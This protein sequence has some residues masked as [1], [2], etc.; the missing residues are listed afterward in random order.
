MTKV[1]VLW[2]TRITWV[3]YMIS[4]WW[5][6]SV[7]INENRTYRF[8]E[9]ADMF[10]KADPLVLSSVVPLSFASSLQQI[11]SFPAI[12]ITRPRS[13]IVIHLC[14]TMISKIIHIFIYIALNLYLSKSF[15]RLEGLFWDLCCTTYNLFIWDIG[16][17]YCTSVSVPVLKWLCNI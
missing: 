13:L 12:E 6:S 17:D 9:P 15:R 5:G 2:K 3:N 14:N 8:G 11:C 1:Y 10:V 4:G 7:I 16:F